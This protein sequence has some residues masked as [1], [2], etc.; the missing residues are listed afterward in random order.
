MLVGVGIRLVYIF[1]IF[2]RAPF[3]YIY[4]STFLDDEPH[5]VKKWKKNQDVCIHETV[6]TDE[7][8]TSFKLEEDS[9]D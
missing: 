5:H 2:T 6:R 3:L 9:T 8:Q 1:S 4:I 7:A